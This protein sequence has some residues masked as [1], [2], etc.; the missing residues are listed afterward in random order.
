MKILPVVVSVFSLLVI[1]FLGWKLLIENRGTPKGTLGNLRVEPTEIKANIGNKVDIKVFGRDGQDV[2]RNA[3]FF[4]SDEDLAFVAT[5]ENIAGQTTLHKTGQGSIRVEYDGRS[6]DI[7]VSVTAAPLSIICRPHN[8]TA[9][10]GEVVTWEIWFPQNGTPRY[11]YHVYGD[12][13]LD[14]P[15]PVS[16]HTY[17]TPGQKNAQADVTDSTG[18]TAHAE[19][20]P[21]TIL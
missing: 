8:P 6:T 14:T 4:S 16:D 20:S 18:L 13:G 11:A 17:K 21:V 3:K 10:V 15:A 19:C 9:K 12:D 5:L 2:T 7:P 1:V